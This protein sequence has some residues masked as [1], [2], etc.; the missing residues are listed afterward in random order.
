MKEAAP[1]Q[2]PGNTAQHTQANGQ[3]CLSLDCSSFQQNANMTLRVNFSLDKDFDP[4]CI[5]QL[6]LPLPNF[7]AMWVQ[8]KQLVNPTLTTTRTTILAE[9]PHLYKNTQP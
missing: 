6:N 1:L 9:M 3:Q 8:P 5:N 4:Y 7:L 2:T